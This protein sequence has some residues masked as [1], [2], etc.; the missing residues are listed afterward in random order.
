L[1]W[2][3]SWRALATGLASSLLFS[4]FCD[5]SPLPANSQSVPIL[6]PTAQ[7]RKPRVIYEDLGL[8]LGETATVYSNGTA[9][10]R[11]QRGAV[12]DERQVRLRPDPQ[13]PS[14]IDRAWVIFEL[15]RPKP[16][17]FALG[18]VVVVFRAGVSVAKDTFILSPLELLA[19]RKG[20]SQNARSMA[21]VPRYTNDAATDQSLAMLGVD[22]S[23]RLFQNFSR[24]TLSGM[25]T[26]AEAALRQPGLLDF[27][28]AYRLHI[29]NATVRQA[30]ARLRKLPSVV[31]ASPNWIV[32]PT[33]LEPVP[34]G[35]KAVAQSRISAELVASHGAT[36]SLSQSA[37][38]ANYA[39][40]ASAQSLLNASGVGAAAA[41]NEIARRFHQLPGTGE[42][43]TN[44]SLGDVD[45]S[46]TNTS[47]P[48]YNY[49]F[50]YGPTT[51]LQGSQRY[52]NWPSMPLI[53]TYTADQTGRLDGSGEVCGVDPYLTEVGLDFSMMA[54]LPHQM[55]RAGETGSGYT[56]LLGIA[57]GAQYRLVVPASA[58]ATVTDIQGAFLGAAM[59]TPRPNIITASIGFGF[60]I[61]GLS[62]RYL[63]DDQLMESVI[64][65]IVQKENIVVCISAGDG[66]RTYSTAAIG[67]S[68]GSVPT[69]VVSDGRVTTKLDDIEYST[70]PSEDLDSGSIDVGGT[71]LD[72]VL[73]HWPQST[74]PSGRAQPV[75]AETRWDGLTLFSSGFGSRVNVSAPSD[76][77]LALEHSGANDDSVAVAVQG[78]TSA[79]APEVAAVAAVVQQVGRLTGHPFMSVTALRTFLEQTG[80]PV[81][82]VPQADVNIDVGPQVDLH[83]AVESLFSQAGVHE[84]PAVSRVAIGQRRELT[85]LAFVFD[86]GSWGN[87]FVTDTDPSN[88]NLQDSAFP[89]LTAQA[90]PKG[91]DYNAYTG[92]ITIAP[93]WEFVPAGA[94]YQLF[95]ENNPR[96]II[97]TSSSARLLPQQILEA[98]KLPLA[99]ASTRTVQ[100]TYRAVSGSRLLA[101]ASVP[102]TF[103]PADATA[104]FIP[105]PQTP[106]VVD[107]AFIPVTYDLTAVRNVA[108]PYLT[109]SYPGARIDWLYGFLASNPSSYPHH[110][111]GEGWAYS[112]ALPNL[113]GTVRIPVSALQGG[114]VY[115]IQLTSAN[116][117]IPF[118]GCG[119]A[120]GLG[121]PAFVRVQPSATSSRPVAP[122]LSTG[123]S[124]PVAHSLEIP[125]KSSFRVSYDVG[126]IPHASGAVLEISAPGPTFVNNLYNT[127]DNPNGTIRD[128]NGFDS[129]SVVFQTLSGTRGTITLSAQSAGLFPGDVHLVRVIAMDG[130]KVVGEAGDFSSIQE[131][132]VAPTDGGAPTSVA[133]NGNGSDGLLTSVQSTAS[134]GYISSVEAFSQSTGRITR[135][136]TSDADASSF[137]TLQPGGI[138][139]NDVGLYGFVKG[140]GESQFLGAFYTL[141]P[142]TTGTP[143]RW[144]PPFLSPAF[145]IVGV[146]PNQQSPTVALLAYDT[147]LPSRDNYRLFTWQSDRNTFGP[148][149]DVSA[150]ISSYTFPIIYPSIGEDTSTNTAV[151]VG[152]D[153]RGG[154]SLP[155]SY[156]TKVITANLASGTVESFGESNGGC[157]FFG[158]AVD[159]STHNA[160]ITS[161]DLLGTQYPCQI[162]SFSFN[163][164]AHALVPSNSAVEIGGNPTVDSL[165]HEALVPNTNPPFDVFTNYDDTFAVNV[166]SE[167]GQ[168]L[169]TI[170]GFGEGF[171]GNVSINANTRTGYIVNGVQLVPFSY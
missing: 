84:Q 39:V 4:I 165:H 163:L 149:Y 15:S 30:I 152:A 82:A 73:A 70:A 114:G 142:A 74:L 169:K 65:A 158:V 129:A 88:I 136:V 1:L 111:V 59:Q 41:Y 80:T 63:E 116:F 107:G 153:L 125:Y 162:A 21:S 27:S 161:Q 157:L 75:Y 89:D 44:V 16:Q 37:L 33:N 31:Y 134:G 106:P 121:Y 122:L 2:L 98:A 156:D 87:V 42:I 139:A 11:D 72:D 81:S 66:T 45:G 147:S 48:C 102:L 92:F 135:I 108:S 141:S 51:V 3:I 146:A 94:K 77:V 155:W 34:L 131:D 160:F 76:N 166:L 67:P 46:T 35:E 96:A 58:S 164:A 56:D 123:D 144:N 24:S 119:S 105:P 133:V 38:P 95:A 113:K 12:I 83:R 26:G 91:S 5:L 130:S 150:P 167:Q 154:Q 112:V 17:V 78:G 97:A 14:Q 57:P 90:P 137:F 140:G 23:E 10:I 151:L 126:N 64:A 85:Q 115:A 79:S 62:G 101:Q 19:L 171:P 8:P 40:S 6:A 61:Y 168:L 104:D 36:T 32:S 22:R 47:D 53:P 28:N 128:E 93:D 143:Q 25:Y 20:T 124:A 118:C 127:F 100:L 29:T 170:S 9:L 71:T 13:D 86:I 43:I 54:P 55:Q 117:T 69:N 60:D 103:G 7:D 50:T 68:G 52:I 120:V 148:L 18:E 138:F 109:I 132:G 110:Q 49:S 145:G 159:S 99:S